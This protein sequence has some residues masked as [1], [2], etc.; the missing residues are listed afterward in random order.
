MVSA[1]RR[2]YT[3]RVNGHSLSRPRRSS[4]WVPGLVFCLL[5]GC[6]ASAGGGPRRDTDGGTTTDGGGT[7]ED[8]RASCLDGVDQDLDGLTDCADPDCAGISEC[9]LTP[10]LDS[11]T[12]ECAA[13]RVAAM[14][15]FTPVDI[16]WI[17]D[18]S[19]S[20]SEEASLVQ[21][22]INSF[23]AAF[24]SVGIDLHVVFITAPGFV[25]VP[26][27]LGTD[28]S[29]FLRVNVSVA[30]HDS[31][32][33]LLSAYPTYSAFLRRNAVMNFI[34][35]TDD[36]SDMG[37]AAF[38][39]AMRGM[40][41]KNF[42]FH[43]IASPPGS[44]HTPFGIGFSMPGCAG[45]SGEAADNADIYWSLS[46]MTG[47]RQFSIC[48]EDWSGL[49]HD[50]STTLAV[51][52]P[53]P[54]VYA[55]PEPPAGMSFDP[56]RVNVVHTLVDGTTT[57]VPNV[58]DYTGCTDQGWYY[59]GDPAAPDQIVVCP[60][61]CRIFEDDTTGSVDVALGCATLLI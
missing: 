3:A 5:V 24:A 57:T 28:A 21:T 11:G 45:P 2:R 53:L 22:N 20:M 30:S 54:C 1:Q 16:V 29:R 41:G 32:D 13:V 58:G 44:S 50:L 39:S 43:I 51:A 19:G 7:P 40:L 42:R 25:E 60:N 8:S 34:D 9:S 46:T 38:V 52:M 26:A 14:T 35:I 48:S 15:G 17:I 6:S 27:P 36:E 23:A 55:I 12:G 59:E 61:T 49:F 37:A 31:L 18:N 4:A 10:A 56:M 47:G 33:I